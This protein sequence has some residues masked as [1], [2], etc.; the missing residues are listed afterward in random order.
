MPLTTKK[1]TVEVKEVLSGNLNPGATL[2]FPERTCDDADL[3]KAETVFVCVFV[4]TQAQ[5]E[6]LYATVPRSALDWYQSL[7]PEQIQE[8]EA[9]RSDK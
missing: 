1:L 5:D 3:A 2:T 6:T 4:S 8:L 9:R 7:T